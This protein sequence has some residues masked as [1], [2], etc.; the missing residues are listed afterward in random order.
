MILKKSGC[1]TVSQ[2]KGIFAQSFKK[3]VGGV[4]VMVKVG[5]KILLKPWENFVKNILETLAKHLW[6]FW[7]NFMNVCK[8]ITMKNFKELVENVCEISS[9]FSKI[10]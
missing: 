10:L 3:I 9:K 2:Q 6:N 7:R 1:G 5:E 4:K 8:N